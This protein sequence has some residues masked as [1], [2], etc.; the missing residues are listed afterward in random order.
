MSWPGVAHT[1]STV[2][3]CCSFHSTFWAGYPQAALRA[4]KDYV[5][6]FFATGRREL[7]NGAGV[8]ARP[9]HRSHLVR[10]PQMPA[11]SHL[12]TALP[13]AASLLIDRVC[14]TLII[15]YS[16]AAATTR[17]R[18]AVSPVEAPVRAKNP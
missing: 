8:I 12:P 16:T 11:A 9:V 3:L 17:V 10:M 4:R 1:A 6:V 14:S 18:A 2:T 15:T 7:R 5:R 13:A